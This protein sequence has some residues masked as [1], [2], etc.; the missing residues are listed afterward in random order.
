MVLN[1]LSGRDGAARLLVRCAGL[2]WRSGAGGAGTWT[3][4]APRYARHLQRPGTSIIWADAIVTVHR[5]YVPL[6]PAVG[7]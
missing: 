1:P 2:A 5:N 7:K 4:A 3:A 6:R